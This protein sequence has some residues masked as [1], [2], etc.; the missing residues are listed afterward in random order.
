MTTSAL[1]AGP[2]NVTATYSG[3]S[4]F[5]GSTSATLTQT[6]NQTA[7]TTALV[8]SVNPSTVGDSVTLTTTV[9][10]AN[11]SGTVTFTVDGAA[12]TP[13]ALS[14]GVAAYTTSSLVAGAHTLT[15]AYSGDSAF[16]GSTSAALTQ[17]V[18]PLAVP[19]PAL[20]TFAPGLQMI[21]VPEDFSNVA[22]ADAWSAP[23]GQVL[24]TWN[25]TAYALGD[26]LPT[27]GQGA[28]VRLGQNTTLY[29]TGAAVPTNAP[30]AIA[31]H[32][33]WNLVGNPFPTAVAEQSLSVQTPQATILL[34]GAQTLVSKTLYTY[35]AGAS[36][37][38]A[39]DVSE[40]LAPFQG[41]W[42]YAF[43]DATLIVPPPANP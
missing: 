18:N 14:G 13:V 41:Y 25:G 30:F 21:V 27:P 15:V 37:Y 29:D 12:Q 43:Q 8:S 17:T 40:S 7:S 22:L 11:A 34:G 28:W 42:L 9:T 35:P 2:H 23:S 32:T 20:H 6:V 4:A 38:Q 10:P 36:A 39:Q 16:V 33:G 24:A 1:A 5:T 3:D 31:L 26:A 19:K